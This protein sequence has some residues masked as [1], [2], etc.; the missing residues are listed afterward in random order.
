MG[1]SIIKTTAPL[2][3]ICIVVSALLALTEGVTRDSINAQIELAI[4]EA[5]KQV[6]P[7]AT[8]FAEKT[9]AT[10]GEGGI[11]YYVGTDA[12]GTVCGYVFD[13]AAKGYGGD[14][15]LMCGITREG[16]VSGI[17]VTGSN[18]TPGVGKKAEAPEF[19]AQFYKEAPENGFEAV[20][21]GGGAAG[22]IDAITGATVTS[23]AV[24]A[25]VNKAVEAFWLV[26]SLDSQFIPQDGDEAA[27]GQL[28]EGGN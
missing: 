9:L 4:A 27:S 17:A 21:G 15:T 26:R 16:T 28:R 19:L 6:L 24:T 7:Q 18:E 20:K 13:V 23:K 1:K 22:K 3:I 12:A 5:Q 25:A 8:G 11:T 2:L 14:V 10:G